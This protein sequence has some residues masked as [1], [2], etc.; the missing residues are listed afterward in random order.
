MI[1][2]CSKPLGVQSHNLLWPDDLFVL[3]FEILPIPLAYEV[4]D[5]VQDWPPR[6]RGT[7]RYLCRYLLAYFGVI[8]EMRVS[9]LKLGWKPANLTT[10]VMTCFN[11]GVTK[12]LRLQQ[13]CSSSPFPPSQIIGVLAQLPSKNRLIP[14]L[15]DMISCL[16]LPVLET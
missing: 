5:R 1:L 10:G 8:D 15:L 13:Q 7:N 16:I 2:I 4:W 9:S 14:P 3:A 12:D 11:H 6:P